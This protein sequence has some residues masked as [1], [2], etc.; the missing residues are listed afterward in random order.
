[1]GFSKKY[2]KINAVKDMTV[3]QL[4][5]K[6]RFTGIPQFLIFTINY[7]NAINYTYFR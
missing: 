4:F 1:M 7:I 3:H 2:S 5:Q 6:R